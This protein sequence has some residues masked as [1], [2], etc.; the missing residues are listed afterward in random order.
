MPR[1]KQVL[2]GIQGDFQFLRSQHATADAL[3]LIALA[4]V[5]RDNGLRH[6]PDLVSWPVPLQEAPYPI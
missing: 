3:E 1:N 2:K 6:S 4:K 5:A